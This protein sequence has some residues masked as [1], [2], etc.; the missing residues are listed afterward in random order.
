MVASEA[1]PSAIQTVRGPALRKS[2]IRIQLA[3]SLARHARFVSRSGPMVAKAVGMPMSTQGRGRN[4]RVS[5]PLTPKGYQVIRARLP[6]GAWQSA[7]AVIS[8][9]L[10]VLEAVGP[11][12]FIQE[13][14]G[15]HHIG[16]E[17]AEAITEEVGRR[18]GQRVDRRHDLVGG[19]LH[20]EAGD[21]E[22]LRAGESCCPV[23][24]V[25]SSGVPAVSTPWPAR[26]RGPRHLR[27]SR[28]IS[29]RGG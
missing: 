15:R 17:L 29:W 21:L 5:Q 23:D 9:P 6:A 19:A 8:I 26:C 25:S 22:A 2:L 28:L 27:T 24:G 18:A 11:P 16:V 14:L 12:T 3:R 1:T 20:D 4:R 13:A 7:V 10:V